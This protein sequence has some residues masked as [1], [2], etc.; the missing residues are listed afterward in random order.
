MAK[1]RWWTSTNTRYRVVAV[2][3]GGTGYA[4]G[5]ILTFPDIGK[6]ALSAGSTAFTTS[7]YYIFWY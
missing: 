5:N 1:Q 3:N 6:H 7:K 2:V 4:A